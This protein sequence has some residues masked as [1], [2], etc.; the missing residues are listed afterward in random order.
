V[1]GTAEL[2]PRH[3]VLRAA[4]RQV[5]LGTHCPSLGR[6]DSCSPWWGDLRSRRRA[7]GAGRTCTTPLAPELFSASRAQQTKG[8]LSTA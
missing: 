8:E 4:R 2:T 6:E 1:K 3:R 7:M 5:L